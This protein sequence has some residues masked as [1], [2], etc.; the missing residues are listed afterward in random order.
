MKILGTG[1]SGLVGSRI[2]ELLCSKYE[3]DSSTEDITDRNIIQ[4]RIKNSDAPLV[5]HLA[6]K[7]DVD[8]CEKDKEKG[9]DGDAWKINVIGTENVAR[10]CSQAQKK[11]IYISTDFVF[12]GE[13][14][15]YAEEDLANPINWYGKTKYEGEVKIKNSGCDFIIARISYPYRARYDFKKDFVRGLIERLKNGQEL[16][17]VEDHIFT[18]TL[19][20]DIAYA[21]DVLITKKQNGIFHVTGSQMITP[22]D[23]AILISK[24]LGF[25]TSKISKIKR[26]EFFKGRAPRGFN[27][28]L[29]NDRIK[30]LGI[31]MKTF[32]EGLKEIKSQW[33]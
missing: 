24:T 19:I 20:D 23:V 11:L 3:F 10:A 22:Y 21:L 9:E 15:D 1:L 4:Q 25:D 28:S 6:A 7:T 27:L 16:K 30:K 8:G 29:K 33:R 13:K 17:M 26:E 5:L 18:P 32:G 2:V 12:D 14:G 31:N